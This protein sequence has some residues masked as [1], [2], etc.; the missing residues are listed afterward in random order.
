M[1]KMAISLER[2]GKLESETLVEQNGK[3]KFMLW[4]FNVLYRRIHIDDK[5]FSINVFPLSCC[6]AS[7][8]IQLLE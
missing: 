6:L 7:W 8:E 1:G 3:I 5:Y 4:I 2:V